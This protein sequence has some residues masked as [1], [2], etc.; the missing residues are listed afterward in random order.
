M[1]HNLKTLFAALVA[2]TMG[3][4]A[5]AQ[6]TDR[7]HYTG[8]ELSNPNLHDGGLSPVVVCTTSR[9]CVPTAIWGTPPTATAGP[10]T[11]SR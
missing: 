8:S 7:I 10:T 4:T 6:T 11:T 5:T 9:R 2:L 3:W 1:K